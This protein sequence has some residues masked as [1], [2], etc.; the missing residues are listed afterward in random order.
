MKE[1]MNAFE[2][3]KQKRKSPVNLIHGTDWW[4][5]CDDV[6]A[7]RLLLRAH[8]A[9][10][11]RLLGIGINSVMEYSA[12]SVS[13]F[14]E[15]DGLNIPIGVDRSAVRPGNGCKYQKL[16]AS[17]PHPIRAN[18]ECEE[19]WVMYRRLLSQADG[20]ADIVD[21]GFPQIIMELLKSGPDAL[22]PLGGKELVREKVNR[23]WLMAGKW[24]A[25]SGKEYNLSAYPLCAEA[26]AYI[27]ENCPVPITFLG[28]E[29]GENVICGGKTAADDPLHL[30]FAAHGSGKGRSAW[31]PLTALLAITGDEAAAGYGTV[32]GFARVDPVTGENRFAPDPNGPHRYVVPKHPDQWYADRLDALLG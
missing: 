5:D 2:E 8:R 27:C 3:L 13:A 25:P 23:I 19:A 4:T 30:A 20:K 12:P 1:K 15:Y 14:C 28:H 29:V 31:D 17:Y 21:V 16:L 26:G 7:L 32:T 18:D 6:A 11:I 24:D 9:G 22:S 10:L